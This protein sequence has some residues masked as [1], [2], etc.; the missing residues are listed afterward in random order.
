MLTTELAVSNSTHHS[1][2][3]GGVT[4]ADLATYECAAFNRHGKARATVQLSGRPSRA[5]ILETSRGGKGS[6]SLDWRVETLVSL[7]N[8]TVEYRRSS[9]QS[10]FRRGWAQLVFHHP[11]LPGLGPPPSIFTH[12][13]SNLETGTE[14]EVRLRC[15]NEFGSSPFSN[16]VLLSTRHP[17]YVDKSRYTADGMDSTGSLWNMI[18]NRRSSASQRGLAHLASLW[19]SVAWLSLH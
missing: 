11:T 4:R 7:V 17:G 3:V 19:A 2:V 14:Y 15:G 5:T 13:I 18:Q 10:V 12:V 16:T 1:L 6:I 8:T 9:G